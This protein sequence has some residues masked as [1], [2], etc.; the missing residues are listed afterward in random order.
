MPLWGNFSS[1]PHWLRFPKIWNTKINKV[2]TEDTFFPLI[3]QTTGSNNPCCSQTLWNTV[4]VRNICL[5]TV[6]SFSALHEC[7]SKF[8]HTREE[9]MTCHSLSKTPLLCCLNTQLSPCWGRA[10]TGYA[11]DLARYQSVHI[12]HSPWV[13]LTARFLKKRPKH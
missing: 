7:L 13:V 8:P 1:W 5:Q 11:P 12:G 9:E 4:K 3:C 2:W 10:L 6:H